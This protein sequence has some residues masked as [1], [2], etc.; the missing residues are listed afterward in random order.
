MAF[1]A[2]LSAVNEGGVWR[3]GAWGVEMGECEQEPPWQENE[4]RA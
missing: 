4:W 2:L 1:A 3:G